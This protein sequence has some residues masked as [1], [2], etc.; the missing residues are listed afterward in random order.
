MGADVSNRRLGVRLSDDI[1]KGILEIK[2]R[3]YGIQ[4]RNESSNDYLSGRRL[5]NMGL[6]ATPP[7]ATATGGLAIEECQAIG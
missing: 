5:F 1:W 7:D 4:L 6:V 3:E 2:K